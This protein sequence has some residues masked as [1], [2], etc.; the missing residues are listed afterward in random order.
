[1]AFLLL[2]N[3]LV[4]EPKLTL[5][6]LQQNGSLQKKKKMQVAHEVYVENYKTVRICF[7]SYVLKQSVF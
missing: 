7:Y 4:K 2:A 1:M 3:K 6:V 5:C